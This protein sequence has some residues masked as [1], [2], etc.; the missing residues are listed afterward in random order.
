MIIVCPSCSS[1]LQIDEAKAPARPVS[2][3]CP[4]CSGIVNVGTGSPASEQSA[5][6]VGTSPATGDPRFE[7]A[8]APAPLFELGPGAV[9]SN[10]GLSPVEQLG[11]L[12]VSLVGQNGTN[13]A[14]APTTRPAWNPRKAL[15]CTT[16]A[17]REM[18]ARQ[19][20]QNG[21]QVFV[22][23]DTRQA[24]ERM[25]ENQLDVVLLDPDFDTA[26]QGAVFVTREVTVLRPV[27]RRRLFFV[28]LS[29]TLRTMEAHGAFLRNFNGIV[30]L[31]DIEELPKILEHALRA[32]NELYKDFNVALNLSPL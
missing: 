31:K 18:V 19:L 7:E 26:E 16:E 11:R 3:R 23:Q 14:S 8:A 6:A 2:I 15:V 10:A 5:L 17:H 4:K 1:R 25:R 20:A 28:L 27:Q 30:N 22:A 21:Y 9:A 24:V 29:S 13:A 12:L 32:Y